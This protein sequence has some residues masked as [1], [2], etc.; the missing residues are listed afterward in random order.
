MLNPFTAVPKLLSFYFAADSY[1]KY[2]PEIKRLREAGDIEGEKE[3]IRKG[4]KA[5]I[6]RMAPKLGLTFEVTGEG[7]TARCFCHEI[8]HLNG[9]LF[10]SRAERMLT[11]E[12]IE[13]G[14]Y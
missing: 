4:Q 11:E 5:V 10:T 9:I 2:I 1:K 6:E 13:S 14:E 12:E 8:D 7:L 3:A